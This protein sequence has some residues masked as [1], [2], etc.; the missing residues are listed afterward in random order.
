MQFHVQITPAVQ[1]E[2][3]AIGGRGA[4]ERDL[5]AHLLD[6]IGQGFLVAPG[7]EQPRIARGE[8]RTGAPHGPQTDSMMGTVTSR[9]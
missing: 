5:L 9:R 6:G 7:S 4:V 2:H 1:V 8:L 3:L